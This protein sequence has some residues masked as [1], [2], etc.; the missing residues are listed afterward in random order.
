M[1][2][3]RIA[4]VVVLLLVFM[5]AAVLMIFLSEGEVESLAGAGSSTGLDHVIPEVH[6]S[7][8][9][10]QPDRDDAAARDVVAR[11]DAVL[12]G[13]LDLVPG[14][15]RDGIRVIL[16]KAHAELADDPSFRLEMTPDAEGAF[17][18]EGLDRATRY[19]LHVDAPG[20]QVLPRSHRIGRPEEIELDFRVVPVLACAPSLVDPTGMVVTPEEGAFASLDMRRLVEHGLD[21][22]TSVKVGGLAREDRDLLE[23][24][25]AIIVTPRAELT[26]HDLHLSA[27]WEIPG[28]EN[29]RASIG[30]GE[31]VGGS[32]LLRQALPLTALKSA[33]AASF[34]LRYEDGQVPLGRGD[35]RVLRN[36]GWRTSVVY[37]LADFDLSGLSS[38]V[39]RLEPGVYRIELFSGRKVAE[40]EVPG[41]S[42][43]ALRVPLNVT[44]G[45]DILI[46]LPE[47][48][49]PF[50]LSAPARG[51]A[52]PEVESFGGLE[53]YRDL[54]PGDWL[55]SVSDRRGRRFE[56]MVTLAKGQRLDWRPFAE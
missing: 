4:I 15:N 31:L 37:A 26:V 40:F 2:D 21:V 1:K 14:M 38:A 34:D 41:E 3:N 18:F 55:V 47:D 28:Y 50:M 52:A 32:V 49:G 46:E 25:S 23:S 10:P 27:S 13:R 17:R 43:E 51:G 22:V 48:S 35:L 54:A 24:G 5:G 8:A 9:D 36:S 11:N 19:A 45:C 42:D 12:A 56:K 7:A 33:R 44:R 6:R 20:R 39:F 16:E 53:V 30:L 29:M